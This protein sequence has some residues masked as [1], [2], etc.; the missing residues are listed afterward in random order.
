[1]SKKSD[2]K[3]EIIDSDI[4]KIF[5][6]LFSFFTLLG[7][8]RLYYMFNGDTIPQ[9]INTFYPWITVSNNT[10]HNL[11][12]PWIYVTHL[13]AEL[14][15]MGMFSNFLWLYL[16]GFIIQDLKG[17]NSVWPLFVIA[18]AVCAIMVAICV[19]INPHALQ[20]GFYY[21]MRAALLAVA[22][23]ACVFRP[24]Y[25]V[26]QM[27][28]GGFSVWILGAIFLL[29]TLTM[30]QLD[31]ANI[32]AMLT[33][34]VIGYMYN[35]VFEKYFDKIQYKLNNKAQQN[36]TNTPSKKPKYQ[37]I[38]IS[39]GPTR[40]IDISEHKMN[41]LLEKISKDGM[42]SLTAVEKQWLKDY[43]NKNN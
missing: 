18:G 34:I 17:K 6:L 31:I 29:L 21:G 5:V 14:S 43:S 26:F 15:V 16:F 32:V 7:V 22:V 13:G 24:T 8:I 33:A 25:K 27:F 11:T 12:R 20:S 36:T 39:Q 1:M 40:V 2:I 10:L 3:Q 35:N 30:G 28:N 4:L 23:A 38:N 9:L 41:T 42:E 19:A 37:P